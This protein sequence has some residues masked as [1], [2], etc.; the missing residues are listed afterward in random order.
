M[1]VERA[2]GSI[3]DLTWKSLATALKTEN[4]T[5][6]FFTGLTIVHGGVK[7]EIDS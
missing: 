2:T 3:A 5:L 7:R 4:W 1:M 6:V